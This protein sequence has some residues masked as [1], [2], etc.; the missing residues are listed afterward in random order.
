MIDGAAWSSALLAALTGVGMAGPDLVDLCDAIGIGSDTHVTGKAFVTADTGL[1]SGTG[2]G[3]GAGITALVSGTIS[4]DILTKATVGFG[5]AG[6]D[7]SDLASQ[8][9]IICV[10][11]MAT[12]TLTST[13]SP[14]YSGSGT[15]TPGTIA[16]VGTVWS[17][18]IFTEGVS[19]GML[20]PDWST[21]AD[22]IGESQSDEV[23]S[24]GSG[25]VTITGSG[26][27]GIGGSGPGAGVI[28]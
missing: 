27:P 1:I 2:A 24:N 6:P 8:I 28:T 11:Q 20:G 14:V 18:A 5:Q 9:G 17:N 3:T 22:A 15:I 23:S 10:S 21:L 19:K 26:A 13:H 12:A 7:L 25:S 16:V 4:S